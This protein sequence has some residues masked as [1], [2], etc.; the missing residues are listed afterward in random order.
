MTLP[1]VP[2]SVPNNPSPKQGQVIPIEAF[3]REPLTTDTQY[4]VGFVVIISKNP[5]TGQQGDLWYLSK[6]VSGEAIWEQFSI[7]SGVSGITGIETSSGLPSVKPNGSGDV[8][9]VGDGTFIKTSGIGPGSTATISPVA[10]YA[11]SFEVDSSTAP[12]TNPVLPTASGQLTIQGGQVAAGT[13]TN[14]LRAASLAANSLVI[15]AQRSSA[16]SSSTVGANG[17]IHASSLDFT[18]D[19]N[20]FLQLNPTFPAFSATIS[21]TFSN[22]TGDG[23]SYDIIFNAKFFDLG[24]NFSTST[25]LFTAPYAG[26]YQFNAS[27]AVMNLT[28]AMT[29]GFASIGSQVIYDCNIGAVGANVAGTFCGSGSFT[30]E[31]TAG[32]TLGCVVQVD[33]STKTAGLNQNCVFSGFLIRRS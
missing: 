32:A 15:Q 17:L 11:L 3:P 31:L 21:G 13:T 16:Q 27:V 4:P 24:N 7:V 9:V 20:A 28:T 22:V 14:G 6:F 1:G 2:L 18:V 19:S 8:L 30:V 10:P 12:G 23:T 33:N 29:R 5:S 25:G 26:L